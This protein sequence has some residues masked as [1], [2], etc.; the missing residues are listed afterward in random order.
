MA[1]PEVARTRRR[2]RRPRVVI[3]GAGFG[4]LEAAKRLKRLP[5]DVTL[6]DRHNYHTFTP[7][8]YQVATAGLEP[9][10]I[11]HAVRPILGRGRNV[12]FRVAEV[13]GVDLDAHCAQTSAGDLSYDYLILAAGSTSNF[14]G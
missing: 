14:F 3:V 7:L 8:L 2:G 5:V 11:A 10:E 1:Q 9:E 12:R 6:V 13:T 4:G